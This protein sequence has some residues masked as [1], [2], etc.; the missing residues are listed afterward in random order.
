MTCAVVELDVRDP[1]VASEMAGV[2]RSAYEVEARLIGRPDFPPLRRSEHDIAQASTTFFGMLV[3][4]EIAAF[5]EI[6]V[7]GE[8]PVEIYGLVTAPEHSRRGLAR[9]LLQQVVARCGDRELVVSTSKENL[10]ALTLFR[11]LGFR[12]QRQWTTEDG[13]ELVSLTRLPAPPGTATP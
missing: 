5:V 12:E 1:A 7:S 10:P 3:S 4:G 13:F 9:R 6:E 11:S 8:G 2:W